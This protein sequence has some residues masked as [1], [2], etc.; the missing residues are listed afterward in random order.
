MSKKDQYAKAYRIA[1]LIAGMEVPQME[2][3]QLLWSA[4]HSTKGKVDGVIFWNAVASQ[5]NAKH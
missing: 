5:S 1:R 2:R 4:L 3:Y